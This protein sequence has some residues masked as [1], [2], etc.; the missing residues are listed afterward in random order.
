M[1]KNTY[2]SNTFKESKKEKKQR[3][4]LNLEFLQ[5]KR[6]QL[7]TGFFFIISALYLFVAFVSY[8]FTGKAD[9]SVV[10]AIDQ[11]G[12]IQSGREA[13]NWLGLY[14]AFASHYFIFQWFGLAAFFTPPFLFIVGY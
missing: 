11:T 1:A 5:D 8:L 2:K 10:E 4:K 7:A 6:F 14:G 3:V 13:E 12:I 9:Q